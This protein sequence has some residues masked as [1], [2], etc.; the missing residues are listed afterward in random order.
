MKMHRYTVLVFCVMI[1]Y[2]PFHI[3]CDAAQLHNKP[4]PPL[5]VVIAATQPDVT[6]E[7]IKPGDVVA[8]NIMA[9]S[10][11]DADEMTVT[12]EIPS[13]AVLISGVLSKAVP[14]K[15]GEQVIMP[16]TV[17]VPQKGTGDIK[18]HVSISVGGNTVF[19]TSAHYT[20]GIVNQTKPV[21]KHPV[22]KDSRG[23]DVIEYR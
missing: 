15:K 9:V 4:K 6:Q 16:I 5:Q 11:V 7:S 20:L 3:N 18:V 22:K 21:N 10:L 1:L 12:A 13:G 17:K 23:E 19:S 14:A 2:L 8:L